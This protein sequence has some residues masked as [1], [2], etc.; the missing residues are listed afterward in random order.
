MYSSF[1]AIGIPSKTESIV[2]FFHRSVDS[3]AN[4]DVDR[5]IEVLN[6]ETV[7]IPSASNQLNYL[8]YRHKF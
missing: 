8:T 2:P 7:R 1:T 3:S 6:N 5:L 4:C